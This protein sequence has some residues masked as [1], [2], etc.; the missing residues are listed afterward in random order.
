[1]VLNKPF[2]LLDDHFSNLHMPRGWLVE[3]GADD[4]ALHRSKHVGDFLRALVDQ[5]HDEDHVRVVV[6]D[7]VGDLLEEHCLAGERR[8]DDHPPLA[9]PDGRKQVHNA[10]GHVLPVMFQVEPTVRM[11]R[12]QVIEKGLL[13]G[14]LRVLEVDGLHANEGEVLLVVLRRPDLSGHRVACAEIEAL[15]LGMGDVDVVGT[16]QI[17]VVGRPEETEPVL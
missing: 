6:S 12:R 13:L 4:L 16:G 11:Q 7:G 8:G 2:R 14:Q 9:L 1:M 15:D 10:G 17:V 5:Q 3:G